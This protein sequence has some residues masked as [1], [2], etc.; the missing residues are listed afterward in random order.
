MLYVHGNQTLQLMYKDVYRIWCIVYSTCKNIVCMFTQSELARP[1][2]L[3][4]NEQIYPVYS[5]SLCSR[6]SFAGWLTLYMFMF[7]YLYWAVG[8]RR[9]RR[10]VE[11]ETGSALLVNTILVT[12]S[13][14]H[15]L[16]L[17]KSSQNLTREQDRLRGEDRRTR[18]ELRRSREEERMEKRKKEDGKLK[19]EKGGENQK[20]EGGEEEAS[21]SWDCEENAE[22]RE[23]EEREKKKP[24][25]SKRKKRKGGSRPKVEERKGNIYFLKVS[26][27][28]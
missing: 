11:A 24:L 22:R 19:R 25:L 18:R 2:S 4:E 20:K 10:R 14:F 26:Q 5:L 23:R 21:K 12:L 17:K 15:S 28:S 27:D 7:P 6:A 13:L 16:T 8:S 1:N 3:Q 9:R